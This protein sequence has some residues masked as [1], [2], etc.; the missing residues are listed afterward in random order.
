MVNIPIVRKVDLPL[1]QKTPEWVM[2]ELQG[3]LQT[4]SDLLAGQEIGTIHISAPST[5]RQEEYDPNSSVIRGESRAMMMIGNYALSGHVVHVKKPLV[6]LKKIKS[7]DDGGNWI[8]E[9]EMNAVIRKKI[10]FK[11]RPRHIVPSSAMPKS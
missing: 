3:D 6:V 4:D 5:E 10:I 11:D 7:V 2:I 8:S 9:L 1:G